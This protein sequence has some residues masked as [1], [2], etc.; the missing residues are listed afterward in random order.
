MAS[1]LSA[2]FP[3]IFG[4]AKQRSFKSMKVE[5][6]ALI[7]KQGTLEAVGELISQSNDLTRV[8]IDGQQ[9]QNYLLVEMLKSLD[10]LKDGG[11]LVGTGSSLLGALASLTSALLP[12]ALAGTVAHFLD[13]DESKAG[14]SLAGSWINEN[15]PGAAKV[16]NFVYKA[17]G[18]LVG[19]SINDPRYSWNK[20]MGN[21]DAVKDVT[22]NVIEFNAVN[23]TFSAKEM[24]IEAQ[25]IVD[26]SDIIGGGDAVAE[27]GGVGIGGTPPSSGGGATPG[28]AGADTSKINQ[29]VTELSNKVKGDFGD[30]K[31]TSGFRDPIHNAAVGGAKNSAHTRGNAIDVS[32]ASDI[33]T[34]LKFIDAASKAG[35]GGIGVYRPG[36]VHID[37]EGRRAWGPDYHFGSLPQWAMPAIQKHL[38]GGK[39]NVPAYAKGVINVRDSGPAITGE[40]GSEA[41]I[42]KSGVVRQSGKGPV[43]RNLQRGDSVIPASIS[44]RFDGGTLS[45]Q[46]SLNMVSGSSNGLSPQ[47]NQDMSGGNIAAMLIPQI[48]QMASVLNASE[49]QQQQMSYSSQPQQRGGSYFETQY[50]EQSQSKDESQINNYGHMPPSSSELLYLYNN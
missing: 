1:L 44:R 12:A 9:T 46:P 22:G 11:G 41:I 49:D 39:E 50:E 7:A 34:T 40:L 31:I 21:P 35:A 45:S 13:A 24:T 3:A 32:F 47:P 17:T 20:G 29:P 27:G 48:V 19:T 30:F 18:G 42:S 37:T 28:G 43:L 10:N 36:S 6:K 2:I 38:Y 25:E 14:S 16:D 23:M 8:L 5:E 33:P 15:I 4:G 26:E